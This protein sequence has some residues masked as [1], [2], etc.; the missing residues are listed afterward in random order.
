MPNLP[1]S[2]CGSCGAPCDG[3]YC[4]T[5]LKAAPRTYVRGK[6]DRSYLDDPRWRPLRALRIRGNP[7]C[8]LILDD[9]TQCR[10]E[11]YYCHHVI[12]PETGRSKTFEWSN[13]VMLCREHH[14]HRLGDAF[15]SRLYNYAD[16]IVTIGGQTL[17][18]IHPNKSTVALSTNLTGLP[19]FD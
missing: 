12:A 11:S 16:S 6:K 13:L 15:S 1:Q 4:V 5:C 10:N 9:G 19:T 14:D 7:L 2:A 18:H 17:R 3:R 8:Q